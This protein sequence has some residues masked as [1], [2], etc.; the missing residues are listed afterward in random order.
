MSVYDCVYVLY[1]MLA[2]LAQYAR[3]APKQKFIVSIDRINCQIDD[4]TEF[5]RPFFLIFMMRISRLFGAFNCFFFYD[6]RRKCQKGFGMFVFHANITYQF[7]RRMTAVR[8][9]TYF[10][11]QIISK[12]NF[13]SKIRSKY[14][15]VALFIPKSTNFHMRHKCER[16]IIH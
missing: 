8:N 3:A 2:A 4:V 15:T 16:I 6:A 14:N 12:V 7:I 11:Y 10:R 9:A 13:K 1:Y 5:F